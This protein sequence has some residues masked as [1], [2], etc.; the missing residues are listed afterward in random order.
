SRERSVVQG[1]ARLFE[2]A[3][4]KWRER[5][6]IAKHAIDR[7]RRV[8]I[9]SETFCSPNQRNRGLDP[10]KIVFDRNAPDLDLEMCVA[11]AE[12]TADF[13][14][15]GRQVIFRL[16]PSAAD[17]T[18]HLL[19]GLTAEPLCE[20]APKR[21]I[22]NLRDSIPDRRLDRADRDRALGIATGLLA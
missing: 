17:V 15:E 6:A 21:P 18:R 4:T 9:H 8:G 22:Q 3:Q 5:F 16:V 10:C 14:L 19:Q 13:V 2:P 7:Q 12:M 20:N 11:V 1:A